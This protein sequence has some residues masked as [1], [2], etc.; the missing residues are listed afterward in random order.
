MRSKLKTSLFILLFPAFIH[1]EDIKEKYM[2]TAL[3]IISEALA[4]STAYERLAYICDSFGPRLSGS[5]NL[6]DA[7]SWI[8]KEMRK[9]DLDN[10]RGER[11]KVPTWIRGD[12]SIT[13]L[14]P[15]KRELAMLGLGGSVATPKTGIVA[16]LMVVNDFAELERRS[17][18]VKGKILLFNAPFVTYGETVSYR[19]SGA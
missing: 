17:D 1:A 5:T 7:I 11:V 18:E 19:Y 15:Y 16:E 3:R 12:E 9:D 4:D 2:D 10:V 8:T 13:I 14:K 6:E